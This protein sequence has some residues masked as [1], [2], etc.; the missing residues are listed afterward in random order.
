VEWQAIEGGAIARAITS[1]GV[2][3]QVCLEDAGLAGAVDAGLPPGHEASSLRD[4]YPTFRVRRVDGERYEVS[5]DSVLLAEPADA[6]LAIGVL[7]AQIRG[8]LAVHVTERVFVHAGA[9]VVDGRAIVLPGRSFAGKTTLVSALLHAGATYYSDEFA[10]LDA[11]GLLHPY[12]CPLSLRGEDPRRSTA[13]AAG[14]LGAPTGSGPVR[15]GLVATARYVPGA[16]WRPQA[17][18]RAAGAV[19][20][21]TNTPAARENPATVLPVLSRAVA[22]ASV[23][24]GSRGEA[25]ATATMLID[26][27]SNPPRVADGGRGANAAGAPA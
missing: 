27:I 20:L 26:A 24:S 9:V 8:F 25:A 23:L 13:T 2:Q 22:E 18:T 1:H 14:A 11:D 6:E 7:D 5:Q 19:A 16:S 10:V 3:I 17:D 12:A 15:I 21:M 4:G